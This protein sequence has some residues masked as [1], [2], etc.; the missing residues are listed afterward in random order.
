MKT[1]I[2]FTAI[3]I[4]ICCFT[5][6]CVR[7]NVYIEDMEKYTNV[8][9][10]NIPVKFHIVNN[11]MISNYCTSNY[12]DL[13]TSESASSLPVTVDAPWITNYRHKTTTNSNLTFVLSFLTLGVLP[14]FGS[15]EYE[16]NFGI[17]TGGISVNQKLPYS[18]IRVGNAGITGL[19]FPSCLLLSPSWNA[20]FSGKSNSSITNLSINEKFIPSYCRVFIHLLSTIPEEKIEQLYF[21]RMIP[22]V[23]LLR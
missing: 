15:T 22:K 20:T 6:G 10:Y 23:E 13:F 17:N 8:P 12:P 9:S 18:V 21:A 19:F 16:C 2:F 14:Y 4:F 11:A 3:A 1:A 7:C 5:T